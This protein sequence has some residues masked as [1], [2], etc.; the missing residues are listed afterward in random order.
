M[1]PMFYSPPNFVKEGKLFIEHYDL[2]TEIVCPDKKMILPIPK[3]ERACRFCKKKYPEVTFR[4]DAHVIPES[5]GNRYLISGFECDFCN[6]QLGKY[7]D[8]LCHFL[9]ISRTLNKTRGKENIPTFKSTDKNIRAEQSDFYGIQDTIIIS[10]ENVSDQSFAFD[11][12]TGM[13]KL[14]FKK[15]SYIPLLV[16]KSVL[17]MALTCLNPGHL[18]YYQL[19]IKYLTS[20]QLDK[21]VK[22]ACKLYAYNFP[23]GMGWQV[24][25]AAIYKKKDPKGSIPSHIFMLYFQNTIYQIFIPLHLEDIKLLN[26]KT[27]PIYWCPPFFADPKDALETPIQVRDYDL[28]STELV[29]GE[30]ETIIYK[31]SPEALGKLASGNLETGEIVKT[32]EWPKHIAKIIL[33]KPGTIINFPK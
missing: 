14:T 30:E 16:Y 22:G 11:S 20:D 13:G 1:V 12:S 5:L 3:K 27:I 2:E 32:M 24:P 15:A 31:L 8:H 7:D 6:R 26:N 18:S 10:R 21:D 9:G 4:N 25:F 23:F 29:K 28:A 17:K 19:A 33:V